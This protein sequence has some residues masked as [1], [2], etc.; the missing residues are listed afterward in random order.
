MIRMPTLV[1]GLLAASVGI[2]LFSVKYRVQDLR[3]ELLTLDSEIAASQEAIHV[4]K[5]EWSLLN[6]PARLRDLAA[7]HLDLQAVDA[8][9]V[10][11]LEQMD[12]RLPVKTAADEGSTVTDIQ[13]GADR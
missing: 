11:T 10:G 12:K 5:A 8:E 7:R 3:D 4:L 1:L 13:K 6:D 2:A 9:R